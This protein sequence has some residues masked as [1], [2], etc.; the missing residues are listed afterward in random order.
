[1]EAFYF[2]F[3]ETDGFVIGDLPDS[4]S[5]AVPNLTVAASERL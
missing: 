1:M 5:M 2:A 4:A 3:G